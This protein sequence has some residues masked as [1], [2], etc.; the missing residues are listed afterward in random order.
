MGQPGPDKTL[1][2]EL[3]GKDN[4]RGSVSQPHKLITALGVQT[5]GPSC[6]LGSQG[7]APSSAQRCWEAHLPQQEEVGTLASL[8][9]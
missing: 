6:S 2:Q 5:P 3:F 9:G 8:N 7:K 4:S 1:S